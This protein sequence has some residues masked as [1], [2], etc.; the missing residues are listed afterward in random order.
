M[1]GDAGAAADELDG[2]ALTD[3]DLPAGLT[4]ERRTE[5]ARHRAA[6]DDRTRDSAF[7]WQ[8]SISLQPLEAVEIIRNSVLKVVL[9][10]EAKLGACTRDVVDA[11]C[12]IRHAEEIEPRSNL[13]FGVRQMFAHDARDVVERDADACADIVNAALRAFRHAGE[14]NAVGGILVVNEVVLFVA[15]LGKAKRQPVGGILTIWLVTPILP[16]RA[17]FPGP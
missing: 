15:A 1:S 14:I 16:W 11:R 7:D 9:R 4:E 5:Q 13:D 12:G 8:P 6:D 10:G 3:V 17:V 2:R